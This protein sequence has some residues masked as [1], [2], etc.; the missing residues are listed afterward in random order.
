[1]I[2]SRLFDTINIVKGKLFICHILDSMISTKMMRYSLFIFSF[3]Q[4][5]TREVDYQEIWA[6]TDYFLAGQHRKK[7]YWLA[8]LFYHPIKECEHYNVFCWNSV[9][10]SFLWISFRPVERSLLETNIFTFSMLV[11]DSLMMM[12]SF[13]GN[14]ILSFL[15]YKY[16]S[17]SGD[18]D[19]GKTILVKTR[20]IHCNKYGYIIQLEINGES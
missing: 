19:L 1:M 10:E 20:K 6:C 12:R 15:D 9:N 4:Q 18:D 14:A 3:Y 16:H 2:L 17:F 5:L 8:I 7:L 13:W 11:L